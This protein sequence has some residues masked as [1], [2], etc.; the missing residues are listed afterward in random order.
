MECH[1]CRLICCSLDECFVEVVDQK[2][3]MDAEMDQ[4]IVEILI[5]QG[6]PVPTERSF[7]TMLTPRYQC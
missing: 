7:A 1:V 4:T 5:A 2:V 6:V 3:E